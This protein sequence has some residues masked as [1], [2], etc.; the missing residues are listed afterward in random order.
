MTYPLS[1]RQKVVSHIKKGKSKREAARLFQISPD[2]LHRR[3]RSDDL[4]PKP[5][6]LRQRKLCRKALKEHVELYP[7]AILRERAVHFGVHINA[8]WF[9]LRSMGYRKKK[10]GDI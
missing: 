10:N 6:S 7:D 3:L 4:K 9:A 2:T 5:H 8:I 1:F